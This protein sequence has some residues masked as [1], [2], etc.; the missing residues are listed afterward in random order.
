MQ[1]LIHADSKIEV[2]PDLVSA[3]EERLDDALARFGAK[4]MRIDVHLADLTGT[5]F[6]VNDKECTLVVRIARRAPMTVSDRAPSSILAV[7]TAAAKAARLLDAAQ[8]QQI[9]HPGAATI[10]KMRA[11]K[12]SA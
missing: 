8:E 7:E 2:S 10:R 5:R 9:G 3:I 4:V 12:P 11:E 1:I 6:E